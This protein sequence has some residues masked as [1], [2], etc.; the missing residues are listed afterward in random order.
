M[1]KEEKLMKDI[2]SKKVTKNIF[3]YKWIYENFLKNEVKKNILEISVG[4]G[5]IIQFLKDKNRVM[6]SEIS[7]SA[8][9]LNKEIGIETVKMDLD[10]GKFPFKDK[11][12][13]IIIFIGTIEHLN[14][15]QNAIN[16]VKRLVKKDGK[17]LLSIPNPLTGH[18]QIYPG[19]YTYKHFKEYLKVNNL[20]IIQFKNY[21]IRPPF[22]QFLIKNKK[23]KGNINGQVKNM[24][25]GEYVYKFS[26][27]F[28]NKPKRFGW[29]WIFE[30]RYEGDNKNYEKFI[31][32]FSS[33]Y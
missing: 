12:F 21:G 6:G 26:N 2:Y 17:I 16:E 10:N 18:Y 3:R 5:G 29:S 8:I 9:K 7:Q 11:S 20:K 27:I 24:K 22:Y 4:V 13:D 15:P 28:K 31:E 23:F 19:L 14:N 1:K 25:M 30:V 32:E 33:V